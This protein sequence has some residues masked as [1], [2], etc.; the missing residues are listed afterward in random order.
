[1]CVW[2]EVLSLLLVTPLT[3]TL[4]DN[5]GPLTNCIN[6]SLAPLP[7]PLAQRKRGTQNS[8]HIIGLFDVHE[9][10]SCHLLRPGGMEQVMMTVGVLENQLMTAETNVSDIG[11]DVYDTCTSHSVT[12]IHL[13]DALRKVEQHVTDCSARPYVG[14]IG[15]MNPQIQLDIGNFLSTSDVPYF[16]LQLTSLRDEIK[17]MSAVLLDLRWQSVAVF[18][19]TKSLE[20]EFR[21]EADKQNI[22]IAFSFILSMDTRYLE[23]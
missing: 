14:I 23:N 5:R 3:M 22:C 12:L 21:L 17:A 20:D 13:V 10:E 7:Q 8:V 6:D 11:F 18:S 16:P 1:M 9:G 4:E 19:A 15:P 2:V